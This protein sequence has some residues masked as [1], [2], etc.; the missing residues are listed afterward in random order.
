MFRPVHALALALGLLFLTSLAAPVRGDDAGQE[1]LNEATRLK[2]AAENI[3][4]IGKV[5]DKLDSALEKGLEK[6][7]ADFARQMLVATLMQRASAYAG[8]V[9]N[10]PMQ[11]PRAGVQVMRLRQFTLNDL[12]R[13]VDIDARAWEAYLQM[14]RLHALPLGD[15]SAARRAFSTVIDAQDAPVDERAEAYALRSAV[16]REPDRQ[17]ED[18]N[19][20]IELAPKKPDYFR[21]RAQ[22]RYGKEN[23]DD[24]LADIDHAIELD[25]EHATSHELRGLIL[26]GMDRYDDAL[27]SFDRASDLAPES[28][29]PYQ[30]RG[31]LFRQKGD[32]D[33]A[34]EQL[35][36]ALEIAPDNIATLLLRA[37][38]YFQLKQMDKALADVDQAVRVQ[39]QLLQPRL[40][41]VEI[42]AASGQ[43]DKAIVELERLSQMAPAETQ[44]LNQLGAMYLIHE[45]PRKAIDSLTRAIKLDSDN[46]RALRLRGDAYLKVG[47]HGDAVADFKRAMELDEEPDDG[48]LNNF[49][50]VLAT[51]PSDDVRDGKRAVQ[52]ATQACEATDYEKPHILSTLAASYAETG[53]FATA[54]KWSEKAVEFSKKAI[55]DAAK[56]EDTT[57]KEKADLLN[58]HEQLKKELASYQ[59]KK[60]WRERQKDESAENDKPAGDDKSAAPGEEITRKRSADF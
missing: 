48:L 60:P 13:V 57:E 26:L 38:I 42:Y 35:S 10:V 30:Q 9:F 58:D 51:S 12:Q 28:A 19:K 43:V 52:L 11:D 47:Q 39:P 3:E 31:E 40:V 55:D 2:V 45:K 44:I 14:G 5:I 16:Q 7:N 17:N 29:R 36:K 32:L 46:L 22:V 53:D 4:D 21:L 1:D 56:D 37:N 25:A 50:W 8:A 27:A 54:I 6:E 59:D 20:A 15:V 34:A 18:M 23:F 24:A 41:R 49:A 33:K